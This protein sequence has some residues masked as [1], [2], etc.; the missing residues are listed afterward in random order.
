MQVWIGKNDDIIYKANIDLPNSQNQSINS[1]DS[2]ADV[3]F[4][5]F[6]V[7]FSISPEASSTPFETV[8]Q[9]IMLKVFA[10]PAPAKAPVKKPAVKTTV[11]KPAVKTPVKTTTTVK[12]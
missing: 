1:N 12:K 9:Q 6:N 2:S 5:N 11:K 3:A 8:F 10:P 4:S 7:P